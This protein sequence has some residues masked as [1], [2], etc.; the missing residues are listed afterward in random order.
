MS[1]FDNEVD[2]A[3]RKHVLYF[4]LQTDGIQDGTDDQ[5]VTLFHIHGCQL[6]VA[7]RHIGNQCLE[8]FHRLV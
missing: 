6:L 3:S 2:S 7:V 4:H 1:C 8:R 5:T